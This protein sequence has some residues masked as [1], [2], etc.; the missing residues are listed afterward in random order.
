MNRIDLDVRFSGVWEHFTMREGLP[1]M[2]I[3]SIY[4][5]CKG[6]LWIGT[7][8]KGAVAF[9]EG[10]L[11]EFTIRDGLAGNGVYSILEDD[12]G[13]LWFGTDRGLCHYYEGEFEIYKTNEDISCL[14]G[15]VKDSRGGLWFGLKGKIGAKASICNVMDQ[16]VKLIELNYDGGLSDGINGLLEDENGII[17]CCGPGLYRIDNDDVELIQKTEKMSISAIMRDGPDLIWLST[18]SGLYKYNTKINKL[19]IVDGDMSDGSSVVSIS[20]DIHGFLWF[21]TEDGKLYRCEKSELKEMTKSDHRFWHGACFDSIGR[22]WVSSYGMGLYCYDVQRLQLYDIDYFNANRRIN[23]LEVGS[24]DVLWA[25]VDGGFICYKDSK[26]EVM[27]GNVEVTAFCA[28]NEILWIGDRAGNIYRYYDG[29]IHSAE[30]VLA[31]Y[32]LRVKCL[33]GDS[34]GRV[35]FASYHGRGFGYYDDALDITYFAPKE[36]AD[37]PSWISDIAVDDKG[38]IWLGSVSSANWDGL[39]FYDNGFYHKINNVSGY[40]ILSLLIADDGRLWIGT[41]EGVLCYE[42][43]IIKKLCQKDGLS[44][45]IVTSISQ[46][47]DGVLWFGTEGGGVCCYDGDILQSIQIPGNADFNVIYD[48][49][50][51]SKGILWEC[52]LNCV[53]GNQAL[54]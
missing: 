45:D 4:E 31:P 15:C 27:P 21:I 14:W 28:I 1:D 3:E 53:T 35:W 34:K 44:Y 5:D 33:V 20:R 40:S 43:D 13:R 48:I 18:H 7:H 10:V 2:K 26:F 19:E 11:Q 49:A 12:L 29:Q 24:D 25:G 22:L 42:S 6:V 38:R 46:G 52:K 32:G 54:Y 41:N 9:N 47:K 50:E 8:D 16:N 39:C 36:N 37:Y 23:C 51:D 17:W 30:S